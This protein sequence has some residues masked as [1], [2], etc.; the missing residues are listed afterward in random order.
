VLRNALFPS[1]LVRALRL[2]SDFSDT[3]ARL[4]L[5]HFRQ[6]SGQPRDAVEAVLVG[7]L[8]LAHHK[9]AGLQA[10]AEAAASPEVRA[11]L[12]NASIR[13]LGELNK[14]VLTLISYRSSLR[15]LAGR[16]PGDG[17]PGG[18]KPD[19]E[20]VSNREP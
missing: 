9:V 12:L 15:K 10:D 14:T 5:L 1:Q 20:K 18:R 6:E 2:E 13:L 3:G 19:S 16:R 17:R 4:F 8:A 7:Q 11:S